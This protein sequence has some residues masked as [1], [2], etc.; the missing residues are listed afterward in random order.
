MRSWN[1][2]K[3]TPIARFVLRGVGSGVGS[4]FT[5]M[6]A[7]TSHSFALASL[8]GGCKRARL[9]NHPYVPNRDLLSAVVDLQR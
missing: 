5:A 8:G 7:S 6:A 2:R 9:L 4:P 1:G 3:P